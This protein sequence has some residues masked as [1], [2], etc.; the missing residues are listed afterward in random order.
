M[1]LAQPGLIS[2][3]G[4]RDFDLSLSPEK[5]KHTLALIAAI[6]SKESI[7]SFTHVV[8]CVTNEP[9]LRPITT[10]QLGSH[11]ASKCFLIFSAAARPGNTHIYSI[12]YSP[13]KTRRTAAIE[14][15]KL[16]MYWKSNRKMIDCTPP[17][18]TSVK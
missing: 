18:K 17:A 13:M 9:K 6:E 12:H 8:S 15:E 1:Y 3:G 10:C 5:M 11:R 14:G 16:C 4:E 7:C 2:K